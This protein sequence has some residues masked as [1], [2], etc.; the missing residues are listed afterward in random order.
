MLGE[1]PL[2]KN[3]RALEHSYQRTLDINKAL[4]EQKQIK[5]K[6]VTEEKAAKAEQQQE[7]QLEQNLLTTTRQYYQAKIKLGKMRISGEY[8]AEQL[9]Q[10]RD[11]VANLKQKATASTEA[12]EST[13]KLAT[14][15]EK[16]N[17]I[18]RDSNIEIERQNKQLT[19]NGGLFTK[20]GSQFKKIF[21]GVVEAGLSWK[22]FSLFTN[23]VSSSV[24]VIKE[25]DAATVDLQMATGST[26]ETVRGLLVQY[27]AMARDLGTTT[28]EVA[29]AADTWLRMGYYKEVQIL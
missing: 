23:A 11:A 6:I 10:Q 9:S 12:Y 28:T 20:L 14:Q 8:S 5:A 17:Q 21:T 4:R 24:N 3:Q 16:Y 2:A 13:G 22:I 7:K 26:R 18:V 1:T 29:K 15:N 19:K 27:N 25:L